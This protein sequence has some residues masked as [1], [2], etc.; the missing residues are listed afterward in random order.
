MTSS[1]STRR[2][3][4]ALASSQAGYFTARQ[5]LAIGYGY[6]EQ[7]YHVTHGNWE[8]I[9]RGVFRLRDYPL[10]EREDL[11]VLSLL[12]HDSTSQPQAVF[13]HETALALHDLSD[14]NPARV[15]LTV[16]PGFRRHLPPGLII[17]R[18][19]IPPTDWEER[20]GY[21]ITTL[22]RTLT[23]IA[24]TPASWPY[25]EQAVRD[26][27]H[28]GLVRRRHLLEAELPEDAHARLVAALEAADAA[29][30]TEQ[31]AGA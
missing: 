25:L 2:D 3:L 6:P 21:R 8:R 9:A 31:K 28:R 24:V 27:L 1:V 4:H 30:V 19:L 14:V 15:H 23:D 10:P 13:S 12:S 11:I 16:P 29:E 18:G 26:A 17:H 22:L 20:E 7:H 5:A